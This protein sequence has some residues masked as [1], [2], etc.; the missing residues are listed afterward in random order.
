MSNI[1]KG[2]NYIVDNKRKSLVDI[3]Y[4]GRCW[5]SLKMNRLIFFFIYHIILKKVI[6]W[7]W[8]NNWFLLHLLLKNIILNTDVICSYKKPFLT[9]FLRTLLYLDILVLMDN[10]FLCGCDTCSQWIL[11]SLW[12][13]YTCCYGLQFLHT[14]C[15]G[16]LLNIFLHLDNFFILLIMHFFKLNFF[17]VF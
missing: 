12:L 3:Y 6:K 2:H 14:S 15:H 7:W 17:L 13:S 9:L 11:I 5:K 8:R 4:I 16:L 10:L 1:W